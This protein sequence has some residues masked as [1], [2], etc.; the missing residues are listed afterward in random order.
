MCAVNRLLRPGFR[1]PSR[2]GTL[3]ALHQMVDF[4]R[5]PFDPAALQ[6]AFDA[7]SKGINNVGKV[8]VHCDRRT[9]VP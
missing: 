6:R 2:F 8:V 1:H 9:D 5:V 4:L 7:F 3:D